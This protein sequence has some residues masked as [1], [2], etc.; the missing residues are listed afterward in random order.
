[1]SQKNSPNSTSELLKRL[2]K[3]QVWLTKAKADLL[4]MVDAGVG[5]IL[6]TQYNYAF[7][8]WASYETL[9]RTLTNSRGCIMGFEC[10]PKSPLICQAC[11]E[12]N[13]DA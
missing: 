12:R 11:A 13:A 1:M 10:D 6:E 8:T 9:Y 4:D 7:I 3:G 5:S 2:R